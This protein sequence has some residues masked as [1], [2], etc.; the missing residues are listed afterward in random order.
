MKSNKPVIYWSK[1][2]FLPYTLVLYTQPVRLVFRIAIFKRAK[3]MNILLI[4]GPNL[5]L[6]GE[7]E[8]DVYGTQSLEDSNGKVKRYAEE[9][10]VQLETR[11]TN[12]EGEIVQWIGDAPKE[13]NG[14]II[15]P[16][17]YTHT[18]I[19]I[20]DAVAAIRIPV[21]EV[22]LSNIHA[23]EEFRRQSMTAPVCIGQIC[24]FNIQGYEL[25][26]KGLV[27]HIN[28]HKDEY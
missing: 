10:G 6:L 12:A 23:R 28:K 14:I 19:A 8:P 20:R 2:R 21:V 13:F 1:N 16:A 27:E 15:N 11:Q 9:L 17:A 4:N 26:L 3:C 25:A 22:H 7:R 5:Q 18:S 24:G